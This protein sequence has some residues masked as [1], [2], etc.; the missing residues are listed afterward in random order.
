MKILIVLFFILNLLNFAQQ[1]TIR[2]KIVDAET[3]LPLAN[4]NIVLSTKVG[5]GTFTNTKGEFILT[6]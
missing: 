1:I 5:I 6:A 4:A 3:N 2:G